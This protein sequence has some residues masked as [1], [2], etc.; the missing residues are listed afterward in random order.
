MPAC[1]P[2]SEQQDDPAAQALVTFV[3]DTLSEPLTSVATWSIQADFPQHPLAVRQFILRLR[4][5]LSIE[6]Y[7]HRRDADYHVYSFRTGFLLVKD[8][9]R[10]HITVERSGGNG[11]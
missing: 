5:G 2:L 9:R 3:T 1:Q 6:G 10:V 11:S 8:V 4:S 7:L